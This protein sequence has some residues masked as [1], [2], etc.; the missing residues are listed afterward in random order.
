MPLEPGVSADALA[1]RYDGLS[2]AD[3]KDMVFYAALRALEQ[4]G[5]TLGFSAFDYA[6][7]TIRERY[8]NQD[9][10]NNVEIVSSKTITEE[11]YQREINGGE[12]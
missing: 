10:E 3:I 8:R 12:G 1:V 6:H 2:G 5:E 7:G 11:E 9:A 4:G